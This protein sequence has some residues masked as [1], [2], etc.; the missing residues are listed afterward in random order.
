MRKFLIYKSSAG[1]GKTFT[2][3]KDYLKIALGEVENPPITYKSIL[4]ITFTNKAASEMK[5]RILGALKELSELPFP[6]KINT[7][8]H[9]LKSELNID[10][11]ALNQRAIRLF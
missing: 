2:L 9:L 3:V 10:D 5:E 4:A 8:A 6:P 11:E 7:L 1:S